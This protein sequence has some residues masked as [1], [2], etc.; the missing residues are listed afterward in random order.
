MDSEQLSTS[1]CH[2]SEHSSVL[3]VCFRDNDEKTFAGDHVLKK[4]KM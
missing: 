3:P 1:H 2:S 4:E